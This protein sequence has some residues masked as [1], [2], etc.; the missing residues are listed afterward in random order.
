MIEGSRLV[1]VAARHSIDMSVNEVG[2]MAY[3]IL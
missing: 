3:F 2:F 1:A